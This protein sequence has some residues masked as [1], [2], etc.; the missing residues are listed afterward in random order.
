MDAV[1][2]EHNSDK[3]ARV[4]RLEPYQWK[5]GQSGNPHG[6][7]KTITLSEAYRTALAQ[8]VPRD[9]RGRCFAEKIADS[10]V[11]KASRG[12]CRAAEEICN[13]LEGRPP[14]ALTGAN[15]LPLIPD[16]PRDRDGLERALIEEL[17]KMISDNQQFRVVLGEMIAN[18]ESG[19]GTDNAK[20]E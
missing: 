14:Q 8:P 15:G 12:D 16:L 13:R 5:P 20:T 18:V 1:K 19:K 11:L 6:R 9:P 4:K 10:L 17:G 2:Q 7:P 3:D